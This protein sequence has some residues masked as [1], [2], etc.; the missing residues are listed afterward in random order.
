VKL[1]G[2]PNKLV[3][4]VECGDRFG[5]VYTSDRTGLVRFYR[6]L[7]CDG[8]Y[9]AVWKGKPFKSVY[10]EP[11][12]TKMGQWEWGRPGEVVL[13]GEKSEKVR[14]SNDSGNVRA[15]S[16]LTTRSH[17]ERTSHTLR[18]DAGNVGRRCARQAGGCA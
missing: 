3:Y 4:C 2:D 1:Q 9:V 5:M 18:P 11:K 13:T 7:T 6:C 16:Q 17:H 10:S 15:E 8:E 14:S 12:N